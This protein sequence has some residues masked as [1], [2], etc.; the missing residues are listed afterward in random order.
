MNHPTLN[1]IL[2]QQNPLHITVKLCYQT[3]FTFVL[4]STR[5]F[6]QVIIYVQMHCLQADAG[7][8][9]ELR[10]TLNNVTQTPT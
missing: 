3:H 7:L 4:S 2:S 5:L 10:T 6:P 8:K 9:M 1:S